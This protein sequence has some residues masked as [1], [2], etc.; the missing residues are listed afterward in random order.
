MN[1]IISPADNK[2]IE[3]AI[4]YVVTNFNAS[5]HNSKPVIFHSLRVAFHL[6]Q[7]GYN[8]KIITV[9]IL[10]DLIK[11]SAVTIENIN[12]EFG[13]EIGNLVTAISFNA[14]IEDKE[15]QF[16]EMFSRTKEAGFS[17]LV[18]KAADIYDNSFY[19]QLVSDKNTK[20]ILIKK[21]EYF[22]NISKP[23]IGQ[24]PLWFSLKT[25]FE[26]ERQVKT[27]L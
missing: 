17:A 4:T 12:M 24:E 13:N 7:L 5:G 9:A 23:I 8:I 11:D 14:A 15:E 1:H 21:I 2:E 10:H 20:D 16:K 27:E 26:E 19:F 3:K 22:L 25:R 6:L 18:V